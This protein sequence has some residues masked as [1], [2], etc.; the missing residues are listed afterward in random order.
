MAAHPQIAVEDARK[1]V[2]YILT[3]AD[4]K[5]TK[6]LPLSG[7]VTPGKE[8]DG[9]YVLT[10]SYFDKAQNTIPSLSSSTAL[11]LRSGMLSV[12]SAEELQIARKMSYQGTWSLENVLNGASAMYR[13]LD[14]TGVKKATLYAYI[15]DVAANPGGEIELHL[16][17]P[18]GELWGKVKVTKP[19]MSTLVTPL[20]EVTG[21]HDL[22]IVFRNP[23][24]GDKSMFYFGG[25]RLE[26]K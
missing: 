21:K 26:N 3:L 7:T 8:T 20:R 18:D 12:N 11:V 23:E 9:A 14:L 19:G 13:K 22:Y 16:D 24:S 5:V 4:E 2:E 17:K 6:K 25:V 1:M 10:A 15:Q